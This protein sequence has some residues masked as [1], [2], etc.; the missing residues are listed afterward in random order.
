MISGVAIGAVLVIL[1]STMSMMYPSGS[2]TL[3]P[4]SFQDD[5]EMMIVFSGVIDGTRTQ[6]YRVNSDGTNLT[7][8][9]GQNAG[10]WH[11]R[12]AASPDGSRIAYVGMEG[13]AGAPNG[14]RL[15]QNL[16]VMSRDGTDKVL[17]ANNSDAIG[18]HTWSPDG[19]KIAYEADA[20]IFVVGADGKD[21][22]INLTDDGDATND[23]KPTWASSN[24]IIFESIVF[25]KD[26]KVFT[27]SSF[28]EIDIDT[29]KARKLFDFD[30]NISGSHVWSPDLSKVA[31]LQA[32]DEFGPASLYIMSS[33][34]HNQTRLTTTG[35]L[36]GLMEMAWSPDSSRIA[37]Q[38]VAGDGRQIY[39][40]NVNDGSYTNLSNSNAT[41]DGNP[42]W[43]PDGQKIAFTRIIAEGEAGIYVMKSDGSKQV[44]IATMK[45][46]I[47]DTPLDWLPQR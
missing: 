21:N 32:D 15:V 35:E 37:F 7:N 22:P 5:K 46:P 25:D 41:F 9:T 24:K 17:L 33:D 29:G 23:F 40:I 10:L 42:V 13:P 39:V 45:T 12:P 31:F 36:L 3:N 1:F 28:K 47:I 14:G 18:R 6:I 2:S 43:S 20:D 30:Y 11:V 16:Y 4:A 26:K 19:S 27:E 44:E 38:T 8:L 34:G